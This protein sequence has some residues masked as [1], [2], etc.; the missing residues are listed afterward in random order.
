MTADEQR[1]AAVAD[2]RTNKQNATRNNRDPGSNAAPSGIHALRS[3]RLGDG[4]KPDGIMR[5][6]PIAEYQCNARNLR[7]EP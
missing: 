6:G 4:D 5:T 7:G 2:L 1:A 3:L